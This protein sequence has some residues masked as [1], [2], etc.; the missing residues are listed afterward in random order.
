M[1]F[2]FTKQGSKVMD[3][4]KVSGIQRHQVTS[5]RQC[6]HGEGIDSD[7]QMMHVGV[8]AMDMPEPSIP[9]ERQKRKLKADNT[10][11]S[12]IYLK[13]LKKTSR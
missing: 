5:Y 1:K 10:K 8:D 9:K 2:P 3:F 11:N 6:A 12:K 13:N 7:R 4:V